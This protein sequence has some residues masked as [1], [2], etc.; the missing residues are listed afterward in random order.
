MKVLGINI[1]SNKEEEE[2]KR[3]ERFAQNVNRDN[4][5]R[6]D[7]RES[8]EAFQNQNLSSE[9]MYKFKKNIPEYKTEVDEELL[10]KEYHYGFLQSPQSNMFSAD[11]VAKSYFMATRMSERGYLSVAKRVLSYNAGVLSISRSIEGNQQKT[12][13]EKKIIK[14][15]TWA[16]SNNKK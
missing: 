2:A 11:F 15:S 6:E 16:D 7:V 3:Q 8:D 12:D 1:G 14:S 9:E 13:S 10:S 4:A 5:D